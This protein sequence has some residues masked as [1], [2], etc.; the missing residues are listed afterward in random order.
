M[1]LVHAVEGE[2][3]TAFLSLAINVLAFVGSSYTPNVV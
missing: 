1:V 2:L 3:R